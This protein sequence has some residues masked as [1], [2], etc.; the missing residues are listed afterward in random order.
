MN[1]HTRWGTRLRRRSGFAAIMAISLI[2]LVGGTL[3]A[4]SAGVVAEVKKTR[5]DAI[6]AQLREL[7]IA[8]AAAAHDA[9]NSADGKT[10][11]V[12]T[13]TELAA[14]SAALKLTPA[15]DGDHVH[16]AVEADF[17]GRRAHQTL[18]LIRDGERWKLTDARLD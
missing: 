7:L 9:A 14:E 8:G 10:I 1:T 17:A 12:P 13:P 15:K 3:V 4:M 11:S 6:D 18:T 5:S 16:V 2:I